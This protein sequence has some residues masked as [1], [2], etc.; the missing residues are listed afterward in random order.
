MAGRFPT[1]NPSR[2]LFL[3]AGAVSAVFASLGVA[4]AAEQS[5]ARTYI[6]MWREAGNAVSP[7]GDMF[8]IHN[9]HGV[10][11]PTRE[12]FDAFTRRYP[13]CPNLKAEVVAAL[14]AEAAEII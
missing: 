1:T 11:L 8:D 4:V 9:V 13:T 3:A 10:K 14:K 2:R 7:I 5:A 6:A 12:A